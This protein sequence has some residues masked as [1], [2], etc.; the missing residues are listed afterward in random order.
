LTSACLSSVIAFLSSNTR[1]SSISSSF[2]TSS[3]LH[4]HQ[5]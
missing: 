4:H 5:W 2:L 3:M 1:I